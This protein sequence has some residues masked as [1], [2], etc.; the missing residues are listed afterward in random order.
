METQ[1]LR[2]ILGKTR[3]HF[4]IS[5]LLSLACMA[6]TIMQPDGATIFIFLVLWTVGWWAVAQNAGEVSSLKR[7]LKNQP[8][9]EPSRMSIRFT[10]RVSWVCGV[11][12]VIMVPM[13]LTF[14]WVEGP[15][16][17]YPKGEPEHAHV[18]EAGVRVIPMLT[19]TIVQFR[20][21]SFERAKHGYPALVINCER[22]D[23]LLL[24]YELYDNQV[25]FE[26]YV[27]QKV[28]SAFTKLDSV[29]VALTHSPNNDVRRYQYLADANQ[30]TEELIGTSSLRGCRQLTVH[31]LS[32]W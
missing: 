16:I 24:L 12:M 10:R 2:R 1:E 3:I 28:D 23:N 29:H 19:H 8:H 7:L 27:E 22:S 15:V 26:K 20:S 9:G 14:L 5:C 6:S 4:W 31:H 30:V 32:V 21:F 13:R 17:V 25:K 18:V 11:L